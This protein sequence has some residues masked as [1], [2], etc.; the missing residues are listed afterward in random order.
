[1]V[2]QISKTGNKKENTDI[3]SRGAPW[4]YI[5]VQLSQVQWCI[6]K[7]PRAKQVYNACYNTMSKWL[8][9]VQLKLCMLDQQTMMVRVDGHHSWAWF[10][11]TS[12][13][14]KDLQK[15]WGIGILPGEVSPPTANPERVC[16]ER[17]RIFATESTARKV[18]LMPVLKI[19]DFKKIREKVEKEQDATDSEN[20]KW[21]NSSIKLNLGEN[22]HFLCQFSNVRYLEKRKSCFLK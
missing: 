21:S 13:M 3:T 12:L 4:R 5:S 10:N 7:L 22:A 1:M 15:G 9:R 17:S 16:R 6:V 8:V 2:W 14:T 20:S 11:Y 19:L 18:L